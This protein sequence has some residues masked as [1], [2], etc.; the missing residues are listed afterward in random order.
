[1][2]RGKR[3]AMSGLIVAGK[4]RERK[5]LG[6]GDT[7]HR[8]IAQRPGNGGSPAPGSGGELQKESRRDYGAPESISES[9]QPMFGKL[10]KMI[11]LK[12]ADRVLE[13]R[14]KDLEGRNSGFVLVSVELLSRS[15]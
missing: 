3:K 10:S 4:I 2:R 5:G 13:G 1:M 12:S 6:I 9:R 15:T 14:A 7:I 8:G 11:A